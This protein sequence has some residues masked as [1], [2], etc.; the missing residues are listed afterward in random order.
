MLRWRLVLGALLIAVVVALCWFDYRSSQPGLWLMPFALLITV[1]ASKEVL[2]L[3]DA[4]QL[5][6]AAWVIYLGNLMIVASAFKPHLFRP[7][8]ANFGSPEAWLMMAFGFTVLLAFVEE[9]RRYERPGQS[10]VNVALTIFA[11]AYVGVL[12]AIMVK[13]RFLLPGGDGLL[14]VVSLVAIVKSGDIGAYTVGRLLGRTKMAP[15]LSPGKTWEGVAGAIVFACVAAAIAIYTFP[16]RGAAAGSPFP[17][18]SS[19]LLGVAVG[20]AG[21]VGD[22]AESLIKRDVGR[23]D[24]SDWMPGFG[25]VLDIIDSLLIAGPVAYACWLIVI[26]ALTVQPGLSN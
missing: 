12:M 24:S 20:S 17:W 7:A 19:I 1:A 3:L 10:V 15:V 8:L 22:L 25:G 4:R 13:L 6:P 14:P 2:W 11:L 26:S 9:M 21:I 16:I 23:K 18:W 5:K